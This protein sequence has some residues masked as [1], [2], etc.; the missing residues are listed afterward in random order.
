MVG[1]YSASLPL[2]LI[3]KHWWVTGYL[4]TG[5]GEHSPNFVVGVIVIAAFLAAPAGPH[6]ECSHVPSIRQAETV[7]PDSFSA[8]IRQERPFT[9]L[10]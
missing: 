7:A 9:R 2:R 6:H 8:Q 5:D 4:W 1:H 3:S 10:L